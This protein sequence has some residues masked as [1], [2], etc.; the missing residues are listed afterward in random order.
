MKNEIVVCDDVAYLKKRLGLENLIVVRDLKEIK[1]LPL[2][3]KYTYVL[4]SDTP[5]EEINSIDVPVIQCLTKPHK[6]YRTLDGNFSSVVEGKYGSKVAS[7]LKEIKNYSHLK[8]ELLKYQ[9]SEDY[10]HQGGNEMAFCKK[11]LQGEV[12]IVPDYNVM[13]I[14]AILFNLGNENVKRV[15]LEVE[16]KIRRFILVDNQ[17]EYLVL[18]VL[19]VL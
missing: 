11:I 16:D 10:H 9:Y 15:C 19:E 14:S 1:P 17:L 18:R 7:E 4:V 5:K 6:G 8:N 12:T 2:L 3:G 13:Y